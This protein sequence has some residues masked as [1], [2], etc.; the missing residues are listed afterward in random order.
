VSRSRGDDW[1]GTGDAQFGVQFKDG[2]TV[3]PPS[4]SAIH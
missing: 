1:C 4:T 2:W 3:D